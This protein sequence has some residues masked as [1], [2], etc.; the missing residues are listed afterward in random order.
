VAAAAF[1]TWF[2][3]LGLAGYGTA[4]LYYATPWRDPLRFLSNLGVLVTGG[5]VSLAGPFPLDVVVAVPQARAVVVLL[6][7]MIG[8][9]LW[10]WIART[11]RCRPDEERRAALWLGLWTLVFLLPRAGAAPG[12]RLLFV[13]SIGACGLLALHLAA[14]RESS[15]R[16]T[17]GWT[18][19]LAGV[20]LL[21]AA[22]LGS[23]AYL[24]AQSI[25]MARLANHLRT[26]A[27]ATEV[28]PT[29]SGRVHVL[30]LQTDNQMQGF[31]LAATWHGAG[32]DPSVQFTL[33]QSGARPVRWTRLS[34]TDFEL[35]SLG[36]PFL[37]SP[38]E[39][40]YLA[41]EPDPERDGPWSSDLFEIEAPPQTSGELRR[42]RFSC[43]RSLDDPVLRFVLPVEGVLTRVTPPAVGESRE[44]SAPVPALPLVP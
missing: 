43:V 10:T 20:V 18:P 25:G 37:N 16:K 44:L 21:V 3:F 14:L 31:T 11:L 7:A 19:R 9:P 30:V 23:G 2:A 5:G 17:L 1:L 28:G 26:T 27:L 6:G 12:D 41:R 36:A 40:V 38:F 4:S 34:E 39:G 32:G 33:L 15:R 42:L 13:S 8:I 29:T 24:L 35:E 22:T